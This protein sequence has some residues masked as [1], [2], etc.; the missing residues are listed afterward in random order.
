M[1]EEFPISQGARVGLELAPCTSTS[2]QSPTCAHTHRHTHVHVPGLSPS[3]P[4]LT[5]QGTGI[6][7]LVASPLAT[8]TPTQAFSVPHN[9]NDSLSTHP[10]FH[11]VRP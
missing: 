5:P 2:S 3:L 6:T 7:Q 11:T 10:E 9:H 4:A 8:D 1:G